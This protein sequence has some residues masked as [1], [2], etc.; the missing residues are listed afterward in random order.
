MKNQYRFMRPPASVKR[1]HLDNL[2]LVPGNLLPALKHYQALADDLPPGELLI[3]LPE[4]DS[5]QY[6]TVVV[7]TQLLKEAGHYIRVLHECELTP[8]STTPV[9]QELGI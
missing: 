7:V 5:K 3:V 8:R 2:A 9:Q 1:A 6:K 4:Q